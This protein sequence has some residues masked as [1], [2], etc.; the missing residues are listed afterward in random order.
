MFVTLSD[1]VFNG[2][3][4]EIFSCSVYCDILSWINFA[5]VDS[6]LQ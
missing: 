5:I 6:Y 2:I 3:Q 4:M 1:M